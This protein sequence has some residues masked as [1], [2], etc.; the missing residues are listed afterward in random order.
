M[1]EVDPQQVSTVITYPVSMYDIPLE[2]LDSDE[3]ILAKN[4]GK[5]KAM[6]VT[7]EPRINNHTYFILSLLLS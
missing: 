6:A 1:T 7:N 4:K 2:S 5:V 3:N